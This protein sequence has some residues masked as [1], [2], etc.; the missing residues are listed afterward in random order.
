M[1][2]A[3]HSTGR[4]HEKFRSPENHRC[5]SSSVSYGPALAARTNQADRSTAPGRKDR[6]RTKARLLRDRKTFAALDVARAIQLHIFHAER[7][8]TRRDARPS[9]LENLVR[10]G[11]PALAHKPALRATRGARQAGWSFSRSRRLNR[12]CEREASGQFR[13][14]LELGGILPKKSRIHPLKARDFGKGSNTIKPP[15]GAPASCRRFA[16]FQACALI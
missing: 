1:T 5:K 11:G 4:A 6:V 3:L 2:T 8:R 15:N 9:P 13:L 16:G 14:P 10:A 7:R 12:R